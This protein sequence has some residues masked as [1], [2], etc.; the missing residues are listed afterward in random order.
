MV[1]YSVPACLYNV[2]TR[3]AAAVLNVMDVNRSCSRLG[4]QQVPRTWP[5]TYT[6]ER[7]RR[8]DR[9]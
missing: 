6:I 9:I 7:N 2:R 8:F 1:K 5:C 3:C 4:T